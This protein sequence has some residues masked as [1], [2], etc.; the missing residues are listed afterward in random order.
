MN[1]TQASQIA[2]K[3]VELLRPHC[4]KI[5]IAGSIRRLKPDVGDIEIVCLPKKIKTFVADLFGKGIETLQV[6]PEYAD[7]CRELGHAVKG[8]PYGKYMQIELPE[9]INLDL[10]M[11]DADDYWRQFA[12][13]TGSADYSGKVLASGW[14][15][16][17][18][19]GSNEGLR[20]I[21]DCHERK[22]KNG[23]SSWTCIN[24]NAEL[25]PVWQSEEEF[26]QWLGVRWVEP[27][28][29]NY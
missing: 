18:W 3:Y 29:R 22:D 23:K 16:I 4:D 14:R 19:C 5:H 1:L 2:E 11:P 15:K 17:G 9:G 13:R 20:R 12:I 28:F 27:H 25:P 10:F 6:T 21:R 7:L 8:F 24:P 26:F